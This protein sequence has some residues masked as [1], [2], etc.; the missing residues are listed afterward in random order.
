MPKTPSTKPKTPANGMTKAP[1]TAKRPKSKSPTAKP[2][3][4]S[5]SSL[6]GFALAAPLTKSTKKRQ[7]QSPAKNTQ[8]KSAHRVRTS[9][10]VKK[11]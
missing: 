10:S 7:D 2:S 6:T 3:I 4:F 11:R 5:L 9:S 1:K 8:P